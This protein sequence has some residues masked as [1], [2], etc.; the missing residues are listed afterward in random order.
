M[1]AQTPRY[2]VVQDQE[3]P[4]FAVRDQEAVVC[5]EVARCWTRQDAERIAALL[6]DADARRRQPG[7]VVGDLL[8]V[9]QDGDATDSLATE[10][11]A[12]IARA[13]ALLRHSHAM[14]GDTHI[15]A[16]LIGAALDILSGEDQARAALLTGARD[17][18]AHAEYTNHREPVIAFVCDEDAGAW[19]RW[20]RDAA[21][22]PFFVITAAG[23]EALRVRGRYADLEAAIDA[24]IACYMRLRQPPLPGVLADL[25]DRMERAQQRATELAVRARAAEDAGD[26]AEADR[27]WQAADVA[28]AD[29]RAYRGRYIAAVSD[30]EAA[31]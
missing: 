10:L 15:D 29:A 8:A 1:N 24:M 14:A 20:Q 31:P 4:P 11:M 17:C 19:V 22:L 27:L 26:Q 6:N 9:R 5:G 18:M 30:L 28:H 7:A 12:R 23:D 21:Y 16:R 25:C 3:R 2:I 13:S